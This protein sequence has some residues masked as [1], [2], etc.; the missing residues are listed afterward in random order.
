MATL[1]ASAA[2]G[3]APGDTRAGRR[4]SHLRVVEASVTIVVVGWLAVALAAMVGEWRGAAPEPGPEPAV[5]G[6]VPAAPQASS[7]AGPGQPA[8]PSLI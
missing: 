4:P 6:A 1:F 8:R 5:A 3:S 7:A 2:L